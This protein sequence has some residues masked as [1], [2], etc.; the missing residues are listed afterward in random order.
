MDA[1]KEDMLLLCVTEYMTPN[2]TEWK[3]RVHVADS[4]D[5]DKGFVAAA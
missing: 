1:T 2:R 3:K 5:W 4:K